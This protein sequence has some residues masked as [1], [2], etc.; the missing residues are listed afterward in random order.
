ML[1]HIG[2]KRSEQSQFFYHIIVLLAIVCEDKIIFSVHCVD[3]S[4][5]AVLETVGLRNE[6]SLTGELNHGYGVRIGL[7]TDQALGGQAVS[8]LLS[9]GETLLSQELLCF[10]KVTSVL[11]QSFDA[12]THGRTGHTSQLLDFGGRCFV[13]AELPLGNRENISGLSDLL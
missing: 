5:E 13:S 10:V 2:V 8:S 12:V 6:I 3:D 4:V 7:E 1:G 9:V 11:I